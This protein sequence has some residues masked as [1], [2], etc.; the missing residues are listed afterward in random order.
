MHVYVH[1]HADLWKAQSANADFTDLCGNVCV[2][3]RD[4]RPRAQIGKDSSACPPPR[5]HL[6]I[7]LSEL[8]FLNQ[9]LYIAEKRVVGMC[10]PKGLTTKRGHFSVSTFVPSDCSI[11]RSGL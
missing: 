8:D 2:L 11:L 4:M 6:A 7:L 3:I 1:T 5:K 9:N 10:L